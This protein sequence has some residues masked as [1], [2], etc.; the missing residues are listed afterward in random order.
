MI[1]SQGWV[2][3]V[4]KIELWAKATIYNCLMILPWQD[5]LLITEKNKVK[6]S[7]QVSDRKVLFGINKIYRT[8]YN[9]ILSIGFHPHRILKCVAKPIPIN[10]PIQVS[11]LA[12]FLLPDPILSQYFVLTLAVLWF[13]SFVWFV[14]RLPSGLTCMLLYL[15]I[16]ETWMKKDDL[17]RLCI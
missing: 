13:D 14:A 6:F 9:H 3:C 12:A 15:I 5:L 4:I 16:E 8:N 1:P 7:N 11:F 2:R 17:T 10:W